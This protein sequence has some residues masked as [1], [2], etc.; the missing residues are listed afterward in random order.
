MMILDRGMA[1][2]D[3]MPA[4]V[5]RAKATRRPL[6]GFVSRQVVA[7][8]RWFLWPVPGRGR[9]D[10]ATV[11]PGLAVVCG[12]CERVRGD[13][14]VARDDFPYLCVEFVAAG[15]GS[16]ELRGRRHDLLPGTVF[17]YGPGVPHTIRTDPR[18]RLRKYYVDF[19]GADAVARMQAAR[20]TPGSIRR[21]TQ[22]QEVVEIFDLLQQCGLAQ[23]SHAAA[24]CSQLVGLLLTKIAERGARADTIDPPGGE[25][26]ERF[27]LFLASERQRFTSVAAACRE[28]GI[29]PAYGCRLFRR[30]DA[31]S[32]Y[33][34]LLR[35]RLSLAAELL[36]RRDHGGD[37]PLVREVAARLGFADQ[38][39]FSRAFKRVFGTSPARFQRETATRRDA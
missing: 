28:F 3:H 22:P 20:I 24:L 5:R 35:Q 7:A 34:F 23:S 17:A 18:Q 6:P 38:Y 27:R 39:Q 26:F 4:P 21:V 11:P 13:Y 10:S 16:L 31:T 25:T 1:I 30:F 9:R 29:T 8:R 15:R 33:Q 36:S 32:P 14:C 2:L 19:L 37:R 12:G